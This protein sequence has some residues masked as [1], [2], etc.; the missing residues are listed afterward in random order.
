MARKTEKKKYPSPLQFRWRAG[1]Y[2]PPTVNVGA[3][4]H[5]EYRGKVRVDGFTDA[6]I[7]WPGYTYNRG[8]HNG[9]MPIL[10]GDLIRAV[11]EEQEV[12]V[13]HYWGVTSHMVNQWKC[14]IAE[15]A[16]S[17]QVAVNLA[18]KRQDPAWRKK[19]GYHA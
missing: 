7:P 5:D 19:H 11:C 18:L 9:L 10:T 4:L 6:P 17:N 13:A 12:V 14:A 15:A 1:P 2:H 8:R 16:N 3:I